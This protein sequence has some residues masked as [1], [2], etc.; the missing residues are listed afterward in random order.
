MLQVADPPQDV[1]ADIEPDEQDRADQRADAEGEH[2]HGAER[3]LLTRLPG[4]GVGFLLHAVD[5]LLYADAEAD[6]ELA[7]FFQNGLAEIVRIE[8]LLTDLEKAGLAVGQRQ[9]FGRGRANDV[10]RGGFRQRFHVR[11]HATLRGAEFLADGFERIAAGRRQRG[12]H[13][14]SHQVAAGGDIGELLGGLVRLDR[15]GLREVRRG[16]DAVELGL[17]VDRRGAGRGD[18]APLRLAHR[19]VQPFVLVGQFEPLDRGR[20]E[21][22]DH[23][24]DVFHVLGER[25]DDGLVGAELDD[26]AELLHRDRLGF[27][28]LPGALVQRLFAARRQQRRALA[29]KA[30]ALRRQL[31]ARG[32]TRD[33]PGAEVDHGAAKAPE[34]QAG[35]GGDD[36]RHARDDGEGGKQTASDAEAKTLGFDWCRHVAHCPV[37]A[38]LRCFR[39]AVSLYP[40]NKSGIEGLFVTIFGLCV[41]PR[42]GKR[43][44]QKQKGRRESRPSATR[45]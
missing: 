30:R 36:D 29:R 42:T 39:A 11:L 3:N 17:G 21:A 10:H 15:V 13:V 45:G 27:L 4:R 6:I 34:H 26:L 1:A 8:F 25:R 14:E 32:K 35:A 40:V 20:D 19:A 16:V 33:I 7:G 23:R 31:Q 38:T 22:L 28:H 2:D 18:E 44:P 5:Q 37:H 43:G 12:D 24:V 9:Q 41:F